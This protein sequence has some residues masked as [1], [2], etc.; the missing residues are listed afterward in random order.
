MRK[1]S[2]FETS[3]TLVETRLL[4]STLPPGAEVLEAGCGRSSRLG[5]H[6][7]RI[8]R[9]V[10]VD[11][12]VEAGLRNP[13]L[14]GFVAADLCDRLPF[15]DSSFDLV[16]ANFVVE[17][18]AEPDSA[19]REWRRVLRPGGALVLLTSNRANP[20]LRAA[21]LLPQ[22][23]R[24]LIKRRGPG[25]AERDVFPAYY[26]ANTPGLLATAL[27]RARFA[28]EAIEPVATLDRYAGSRRLLG[29][30]LRLAERFLP[31][32]RRSTIVG[33]FRAL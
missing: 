10:W 1:V 3:H 29:A 26:R 11:L 13:A 25:V 7:P 9:L 6:R 16:Y 21:Q 32:G 22:S 2:R 31:A 23:L 28:A 15:P 17:H 20:I 5:T 24:V 18:L 8:A 27:A 4:A 30:A 12:D 33:C 19:F 14:D